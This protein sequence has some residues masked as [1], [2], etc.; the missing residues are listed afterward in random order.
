MQY[1]SR[2]KSTGICSRCRIHNHVRSSI[3]TYHQVYNKIKM[4]G[5]TNVAGTAFLFGS[6]LGFNGRH[7]DQVSNNMYSRFSVLCLVFL[8]NAVRVT[9]STMTGATSGAGFDHPFGG[10]SPTFVWFMLLNL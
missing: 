10:Q 7:V 6:P 4:T 1:V 8:F 5:V 2:R 9:I 3:M